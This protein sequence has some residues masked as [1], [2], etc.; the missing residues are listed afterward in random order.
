MKVKCN[1]HVRSVLCLSG[2]FK[3]LALF[4]NDLVV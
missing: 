3:A 4:L 1:L 2:L